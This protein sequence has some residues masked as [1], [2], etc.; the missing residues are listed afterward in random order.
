[1]GCIVGRRRHRHGLPDARG[2][3]LAVNTPCRAY[4]KLRYG[5]VA[6]TLHRFADQ[7]LP[8]LTQASTGLA[9]VAVEMLTTPEIVSLAN[10]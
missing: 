9:L 1:M 7:F 5:A 10:T 8:Y 2:I 6:S 4:W 3:A